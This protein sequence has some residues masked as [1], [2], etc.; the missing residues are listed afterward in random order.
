M[1]DNW[2]SNRVFT[3]CDDIDAHCCAASD[4]ELG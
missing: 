2:L 4:D 3:G 1:R